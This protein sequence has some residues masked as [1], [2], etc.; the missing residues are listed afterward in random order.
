MESTGKSLIGTGLLGW[1]LRRNSGNVS[2]QASDKK[3]KIP[4]L[5]AGGAATMDLLDFWKK[6]KRLEMIKIKFSKQYRSELGH[7]L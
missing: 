4:S 6:I 2:L 5:Y 1:R 3:A 7:A